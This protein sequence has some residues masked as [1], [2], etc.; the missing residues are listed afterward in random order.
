MIFGWLFKKAA[1]YGR[2][3]RWPT[4]R[5][6]HLEREPCCAACGRQKNVEVDHIQPYHAAPERELDPTNLISLCRD[7]CHFVFGHMLHWAR[8][9]PM[10]REDAARYR[11][12]MRQSKAS[13]WRRNICSPR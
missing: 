12:R 5:D 11:E 6:E 9:N 10:V 7:P 1:E 8:C 3:G 2:S 4:V 13:K